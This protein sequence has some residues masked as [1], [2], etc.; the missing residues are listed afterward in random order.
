MWGG[1]FFLFVREVKVSGELSAA[2]F[3]VPKAGRWGWGVCLLDLFPVSRTVDELLC[4]PPS[5]PTDSQLTPGQC[6]KNVREMERTE[7]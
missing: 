5:C 2:P 4:P 6:R 1:V 3:S 7:A